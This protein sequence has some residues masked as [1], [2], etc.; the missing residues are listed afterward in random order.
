ME[1][2]GDYQKQGH[3]HL[4]G[5]VEP[6]IARA[7]MSTLK[8]DV[9][10]GPIPLSQVVEYAAVLRRP[11]YEGDAS[12][13]RPLAFFLWGL[14]P[15]ISQLVGRPVLPSYCYFRVYREGDIC[16]IHSDRPGSEHGLSLTLDY[17]DGVPWDL[18]VA[19]EPTDV[20]HVPSS[21]FGTLA[22]SSI[23]M[24]VGDA[25]LY[26]ASRYAHGRMS[27]NPNSW[28]AHLFLFYVDKQGPFRRNA[29]EG[30]EARQNVN[31]QFV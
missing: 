28:S 3:A 17:S 22:Y 21:D 12:G 16:R 9:A 25:V 4:R 26:S 8:E 23:G 20:P 31:L 15:M 30:N 5:L 27:P 10:R 24:E 14:T 13:Y 7:F 11:A 19:R 2:V 29:F 1:V 6:E 18:E